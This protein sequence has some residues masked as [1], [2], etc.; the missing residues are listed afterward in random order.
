MDVTAFQNELSSLKRENQRLRRAEMNLRQQNAYLS[1]LHETSLGFM[2]LLDKE[3]LL[4]SILNRACRLTGT[5][6]GYIYLLDTAETRLLEWLDDGYTCHAPVGKFKPNAFGLHDTIGNV[7]EW[8]QDSMGN[9]S[10][11]SMD[12]SAYEVGGEFNR[13]IRG[14]AWHST[15]A[16]CRSA[17]R[18]Q[19]SPETKGGNCGVRPALSLKSQG[20]A[21]R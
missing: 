5:R 2:G 18:H 13:I 19:T 7:F 4:E 21:A 20:E 16:L 15:V 1:A 17:F 6:H 12:G 14:G 8:C 10:E 3:E 9:Y 11:S